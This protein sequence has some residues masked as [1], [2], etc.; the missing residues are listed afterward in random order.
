MSSLT[1]HKINNMSGGRQMSSLTK[2][3][4]NNMSGGRQMSSHAKHKINNKSGGQQ[5]SSHTICQLFLPCSKPGIIGGHCYFV[6][7]LLLLLQYFGK[8]FSRFHRYCLFVTIQMQV[9]ATFFAGFDFVSTYARYVHF[10]CQDPASFNSKSQL[11][12]LNTSF[13]C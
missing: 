5:M 11:S 6:G 4:I 13:S 1:K 9:V 7:E 3:K 8:T 10:D 2:H 12:L